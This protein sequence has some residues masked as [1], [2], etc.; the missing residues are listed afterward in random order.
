MTQRRSKVD[1]GR[2]SVSRQLRRG[3]P[4]LY[5]EYAADTGLLNTP[6]KRAWVGVLFVA[7][8][9]IPFVTERDLTSLV[10]IA[11]VSAIG[12]IGLNLVT[13]YAG[14][15][16]LGHAFFLGLGAYT[17]AFFGGEDPGL[18]GLGLDMAIWLPL[19]GLVPAAVG[20]LVAPLAARVR[21][22]YLAIVTLGLVFLGLHVFS[23]LRSFTGGPGIGRSAAPPTFLGFDLRG[24]GPVLGVDLAGPE[25][26]YLFCLV[27]LV[28][29]VLAARN[30][31]RSRMGRAFAAVRD[32]DI[33]AEVMGVPLTR[34]KVIAFG[35]SSF[36][37]G[38]AGA[39]LVIANGGYIEPTYFGLFLSVDF[40]AMILIGGPATIS[41]SLAGAAFVTLL[42]RVVRT[43]G[44]STGGVVGDSGI[45]S[46]EQLENVLFGAFIVG[47]LILEPRG[48]YG[49]W[50]RVRNYW[51]AWPFSY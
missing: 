30:L 16:S 4:A 22:L 45:L 49:L 37:A 36:Y 12:A 20:L 6:G 51:K 47:F 35:I 39:L 41:G 50:M 42:P 46:T 40:L 32:R 18:R 34:T 14:Q 3:R 33:A 43:L 25:R 1:H 11:I 2:L 48:L 8:L 24:S 9:V 10:T 31:A 7:M 13:G 17:A 15:V 26:F 21:G 44:E 27:L 29:G 5:T 38:I 19:A 28:I 23:E